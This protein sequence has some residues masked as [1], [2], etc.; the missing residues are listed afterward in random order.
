MN[1]VLM[2]DASTLI[3]FLKPYLTLDFLLRMAGGLLVILILWILYKLAM[4]TVSRIPSQKMTPQRMMLIRK[5]IKYLYYVVLI[6]FVLSLFGIRLSAVWGAAGIAGVAIGFA[7]QTSV[8]NLISGVFVL[9]EGALKVGDTIIVDDITGVVDTVSLLSVRVHT[10]DNQMVRIPNSTILNSNLIN[11]NYF[12][13]RRITINV[14]VSYD[15]DLE[16]AL[17]VLKQ[18]PA[19]CAHVL[20]DPE[21]KVWLNGFGASGI[22]FVVAGWFYPADFLDAKNELYI[23]IKKGLDAAGISIPYD[24]LD[25]YVKENGNG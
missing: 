16:K 14:S 11:N 23:E 1:T 10:H 7:A 25:V 20:C 17:A 24:K 5:F 3:D 21:P 8:S 22:E 9:T 13:Q 12:K 19:R 6:L 4:K 15:T 2:N 18:V